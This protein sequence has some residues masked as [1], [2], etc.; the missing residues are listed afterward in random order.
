MSF[1]RYFALNDKNTDLNSPTQDDLTYL[2]NCLCTL[3][4][5][6]PRI[7]DH[8]HIPAHEPCI[9][10]KD[11]L[12]QIFHK[13]KGRMTQDE[14][15]ELQ[16]ALASLY[17]VNSEFNADH[18]DE[19][20][21]LIGK[22]CQCLCYFIAQNDRIRIKN[23][24]WFLRAHSDP[25]L[26]YDSVWMVS[27]ELLKAGSLKLMLARMK[28]F[29]QNEVSRY[30]RREKRMYRVLLLILQSCDEQKRTKGRNRNAKERGRDKR[31]RKSIK[32]EV[33]P[34]DY[35]ADI[36]T[37]RI[38]EILRWQRGSNREIF[39]KVALDERPIDRVIYV[40]QTQL[41]T[42]EKN[43]L[44]LAVKRIKAAWHHANLN[45]LMT[46]TN[47]RV[48][49]IEFADKVC[50][51]LLMVFHAGGRYQD[52]AAW[53]LLVIC[54]GRLFEELIADLTSCEKTH[55]LM[56]RKSPRF[57]VI[58][59]ISPQASNALTQKFDM[60][61]NGSN[62]LSLPL[63][64]AIHQHIISQY[65]HI[66]KTDMQAQIIELI[67]VLKIEC[68]LPLLTENR[69]K[70]LLYKTLISQ[71]ADILLASVI[72]GR[73]NKK[74][75]SSFYCSL[76]K[77]KI[78]DNYLSAIKQI[79][80]A[81]HQLLSVDMLDADE[82]SQTIGSYHVVT[83]QA[84]SKIMQALREN[85]IQLKQRYDND[86][87]NDSFIAYFNAYTAW[88]WQSSLLLTSVRPVIGSPG[89]LSQYD[90]DLGLL[91]VSD[92]QQRSHGNARIVPLCPFLIKQ[93]K[94]YV[95]FLRHVKQSIGFRSSTLATAIDQILSGDRAL[96]NTVDEHLHLS[97]IRPS[98][99]QNIG[100]KD[101]SMPDNWARHFV[102][103]YLAEKL[104]VS[105]TLILAIYGHELA[106]Q[107]LLRTTSSL[108]LGS[109]KGVAD[110]F[111]VMAKQLQLQGV[112]AYGD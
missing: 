109:I 73:N 88:L 63:P 85:A 64:D 91:R 77:Q 99:M 57:D 47:L 95:A 112:I 12:H 43:S 83:P 1:D 67:G 75:A 6:V 93:I 61:Q 31:P 87:S 29:E 18:P 5:C 56:D 48:L 74:M 94:Q 4:S 102:R 41:S 101:W 42:L 36:D 82:Q 106:G 90:L 23:T 21:Q 62:T 51:Q 71:T 44:P 3:A 22:L 8:I 58:V 49:P 32:N 98:A 69:L 100:I 108:G 10:S 45:E 54:T 104:D 89:A 16:S 20:W 17:H 105:E 86:H 103:S 38:T 27:I 19:H 78:L 34:C 111:E 9:V 30:G 39:E 107:E 96:F 70:N 66:N 13:Y 97:E 7:A 24:S 35:D 50:N 79:S 33:L 28:N 110:A 68:N 60:L 26:Q 72:T 65:K 59:T 81:L 37:V 92:K 84:V 14:Y 55:R 15:H 2:R 53:L 25:K 11:K 52:A 80:P 40:D 76:P 46:D